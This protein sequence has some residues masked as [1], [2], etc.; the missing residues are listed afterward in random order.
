MSAQIPSWAANL[1]TLVVRRIGG[2]SSTIVNFARR[3]PLGFT[4]GLILV[5]AVLASALAPLLTPY[6]PLETRVG[7]QWAGIGTVTED[8]RLLVLGADEMGRDEFSRLL[9][10][11]RISLYVGFLTAV[12]GV[13]LG[14]I[15]GIVSAYFGG[16]ADAIIERFVDAFMSIPGIVLAMAFILAIGFG[17]HQVIVAIALLFITWT[18]RTMR[19]NALAVKENQYIE[20]AKSIGCSNMRILLFHI[21]P[22]CLASYI[23]L[24]TVTFGAAIT[25]EAGLSFLGV[26]IP[27]PTP[28]WG[29]MLTSV[30]EYARAAP[31]LAIIPG[32][33]ISVVVFGIN[34]LGDALRDVLDPRLR[35]R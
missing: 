34:L 23:V 22:N 9:L 35:G 29:N 31:H 7:P 16:W 20:A 27:P 33:T 26:G 14:A 2:I 24:F 15:V 8:G 11:G 28:S 25:I 5:I 30:Q 3:K 21:T 1:D 19:S 10:G 12:I 4:G 17:L 32:A 6:D 13:T 18:S